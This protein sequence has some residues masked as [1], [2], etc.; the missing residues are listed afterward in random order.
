MLHLSPVLVIQP[1]PVLA[2][3]VIGGFPGEQG[4]C[5]EDSQELG[6]PG[7]RPALPLSSGVAL[8]GHSRQGCSRRVNSGAC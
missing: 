3:W 7:P 2:R 6:V 8:L 1:L 4:S 5:R